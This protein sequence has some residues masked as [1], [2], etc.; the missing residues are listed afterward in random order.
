MSGKNISIKFCGGCNPSINRGKLAAAVKQFLTEQG[1]NVSY[2]RLDADLV[3]FLSGCSANCSW[4]YSETDSPHIM[5]AGTAIDGFAATKE[6]LER[7]LINKIKIFCGGQ[8]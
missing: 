8:S 2:N 7:E 5:I 6:N 4:R 1:H 3:V